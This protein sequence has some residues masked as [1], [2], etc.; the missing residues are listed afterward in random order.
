MSKESAE[1]EERIAPADRKVPLFSLGR[2]WIIARGTVTQLIRMKTLYFL[3][4]FALIIVAF[5]NFSLGGTAAKE[6]STIKRAC[7]GAMDS[8]AWM[9]AIIST[10]L[11][12]PRDQEDRTLYTIL[13]KPVR[14]ME[15]LVGK[16][17]GV[18]VVIGVFLALMFVV[19]S[20]ILIARQSSFIGDE[21]SAM[22]QNS[23]MSQEQRI[24][25]IEFIQRQGFRFEL[26]ISAIA[27]FLKA[28]VIASV[29]IL[30]STFASSSLFTIVISLL[31]FLI[32]HFHSLANSFY[33]Y[34]SGDNII[35]QMLLK[36]VKILIPDFQLYAFSEGIVMGGA[37]I[38]PLVW[39]MGLITVGYLVV[40]LMLSALI[41]V[42]KEF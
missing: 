27:S 29:T 36:L 37:V 26:G 2:A 6:L 40:F 22:D 25:Q 17:I 35:V 5:G 3:L 32:G 8:F 23:R 34:H 38:Y 12:I 28:A 4:A 14:R 31:V 11:L 1:K 19:T 13:S 18:L 16:L 42:D 15:Y 33:K 7:F 30:L 20:M 41:F 21:L 24:A 9:F 39:Q 10:A